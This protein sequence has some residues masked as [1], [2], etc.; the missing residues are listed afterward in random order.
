MHVHLLGVH[1]QFGI[2]HGL[3]VIK[4]YSLRRFHT[5]R[6]AGIVEQDFDRSEFIW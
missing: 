2:D 4:L 1:S 3:P 6:Q 5:R